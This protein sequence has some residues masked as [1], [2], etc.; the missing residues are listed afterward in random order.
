[1]RRL[2]GVAGIVGLVVAVVIAWGAIGV[3]T[4]A[5]ECSDSTP[6][7]RQ[8][9]LGQERGR[10]ICPNT[11][12]HMYWFEAKAGDRV[13]VSVTSREAMPPTVWLALCEEWAD[14][15]CGREATAGKYCTETQCFEATREGLGEI[16][17]GDEY[18]LDSAR[19]LDVRQLLPEIKSTGRYM[20]Y[21]EAEIPDVGA[22]YVLKVSPAWCYYQERVA[23]ASCPY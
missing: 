12:G 2:A 9:R 4:V 16:H 1:M 14:T 21:I 3:E 22:D 15:D 6:P 17:V 18:R 19:A 7:V 13:T 5:A 10:Q 20:V 23:A 11:P 8:I